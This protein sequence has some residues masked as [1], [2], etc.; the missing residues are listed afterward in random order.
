[1]TPGTD[2]ILFSRQTLQ[3][4][5]EQA[6]L[7]LLRRDFCPDRSR[8]ESLRCVHRIEEDERQFGQQ[9]WFFEA[10]GIDALNRRHMLYGMIEIAIQYGLL[11]PIR[12]AMFESDEQRQDFF[13]NEV[14]VEPQGPWA[15]RSTRFWVRT[16][17]VAVV[18]VSTMWASMVAIHLM[19]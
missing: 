18:V 2:P 8:V 14:R 7:C 4:V 13:R 6:R 16:A 5:K 11:E 1:M 10:V 17:C 12:T 19:Q 3:A 9:V 15:H